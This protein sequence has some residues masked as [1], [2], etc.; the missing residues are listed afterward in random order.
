MTKKLLVMAG[1]TGGHV[2]PA[3]AV[4]KELQQQGWDIRWL[5][6]KDR[7]EAELVPKYGI[8]IEFIQ[9]S[10]IKGKGIKALLTA[11]FAI[12][13]AVFQARKII[14]A[15]QPDAVLGMGGYVSGPGG[16]AAKLCGVPVIL[17]EQNAVAGLTNV[18]LSKIAHKTLQAFPTAFAHA[19]VVGNPVRQDL[20]QIAPPEQ[21]F[22]EKGYP[23]NILVMGGSQGAMVINQTVPE[24]AKLF[25]EQVFISHQVGKGKLAGVA[26]IYQAT[27]NGIASE[28]I[29]D[30]KAAYEWADL[31]ICRS[32]ALTVCEIAAAGL[33]AIFVPFQH[34]DRQ[35][36]FNAE[37]LA[38]SGA[39]III[40]Q[41]DFNSESLAQA[42]AP[43]IAD[44]QKLTEMAIKAKEKATPLAA[45]RV[46]DVIKEHCL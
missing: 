13:R 3:I 7:M 39:A 35:Q 9:I 22:A 19:E 26:E 46:A 15:Y 31:V 43:L 30:M 25:G 44:R 33:P 21:R 17:H 6:T 45:K 36:F 16:I 34:K 12:L 24:M 40:E 11:P 28:F 32:G 5:G 29:D 20:F 4:A 23:I 37:Y 41:K 38:Q 1:G 2:F 10:G 8:P 18:W 14:K 27:G 42:L